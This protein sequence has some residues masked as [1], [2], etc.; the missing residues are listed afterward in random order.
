MMERSSFLFIT[1]L[2]AEKGTVFRQDLVEEDPPDGGVLPLSV[3]PHLD[4]GVQIHFRSVIG[5]PNLF[6]AREDLP[7]ALGHGSFTGEVID[8]EDDVLAGDDD[9]VA[10][11]R[12]ED[13]V[14]GHHQHTGLDLGLD[15][16][17]HVNGHLIA[18]EIRVERG[19]DE[20]MKLDRLPFDQDG[21]KRLDA[22]PVQG[23]RAVQQDAVLP[24]HLVQ[25]IP[26]FRGLPLHHLLGGLD[27]GG[28][29]LFIQ[30][31]VDEGLEELEGHPLGEAAL[32]EPE[33][34]ADHDDRT[35]RVVDALPEE[36]L[37][38]SSP[39]CPSTCRSGT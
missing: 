21:L 18:V 34:R 28:Q 30:L 36:V 16:Q 26:D 12:G 11:G 25:G 17:G 20:R 5:H 22:Q 10:V 3:D 2:T 13:V 29:T 38:E 32:V 37:P 19:A 35:A 9:R 31:V 24:H 14:G 27:G 8:A 6:R 1:L 33:I 4:A 39:A 23:G 15:G 7:L